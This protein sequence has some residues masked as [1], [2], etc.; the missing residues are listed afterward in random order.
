VVGTGR[1]KIVLARLAPRQI[2]ESETVAN[3]HVM[4]AA[5]ET[6]RGCEEARRFLKYY[7]EMRDLAALL[8]CAI[9][10]AKGAP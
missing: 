4:A 10:K 2:P 9:A 7:P 6:L 5:R 3:A 1:R 8:D